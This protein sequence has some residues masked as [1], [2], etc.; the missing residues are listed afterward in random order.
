[1]PARERFLDL[2]AAERGAALRVAAARSGRPADLLEKDTWVVWVLAALFEA[3]FGEHLCFKGGTSL[4][5][6]YS[7]IRRFSEDLDLT[8]D[9]RALLPRFHGEAGP[10][11]IP[12]N[13]S[14]AKRA[15]EEARA[16]L[17]SWIAGEVIPALQARIEAEG[18]ALTLDYEGGE[19]VRV[20]YQPVVAP[21]TGYVVNTVLLEFGARSTGEPA[22]ERRVV[23]DAAPHLEELS[24]PT[25]TPRVMDAERTFWEKATAIHVYCRQGRL[26]GE[27]YA[28]HWYD[29]MCLDQIGVVDRA[30]ADRELAASVAAHK[31]G[32]FREKDA[33]GEPID[34]RDAV[35]SEGRRAALQLVPVGASLAVLREDY[36]A[37]L[38]AGLVEGDAPSFEEVM[39]ACGGIEARANGTDPAP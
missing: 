32:F 28:R 29:L 3:P 1:M 7:A 16:A 4:S 22:H 8:Y 37:M 19:K 33:A 9:I 24:F 10:E 34:Y 23:C 21:A 31:N 20:H 18:V 36:Q 39:E 38:D 6:A 14:Q 30:L 15:S 11:V 12:A 17:P 35:G 25:A 13:N 26:R 27:R 5:K 2:D